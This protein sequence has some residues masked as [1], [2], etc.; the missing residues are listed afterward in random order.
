[1]PEMTAD[2]LA[3]FKAAVRLRDRCVRLA[4]ERMNYRGQRVD[5][6]ASRT[7]YDAIAEVIREDERERLRAAGLLLPEGAETRT[8]WGW[9]CGHPRAPEQSCVH[10][11]PEDWARSTATH[12]WPD[13]A[14][15]SRWTAET[16]WLAVGDSKPTGQ[17]H[18]EEC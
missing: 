4:V 11:G 8:E 14:L 5:E 15:V 10:A 2:D 6:Q 18:T 17:D 13:G 7:T 9:D 12:V 1:M 16:P 3:R